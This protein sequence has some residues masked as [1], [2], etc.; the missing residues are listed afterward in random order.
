MVATLC[1]LDAVLWAL[2]RFVKSCVSGLQFRLH[3]KEWRHV[4]G[5]NTDNIYD[6][7]VIKEFFKND[8][9]ELINK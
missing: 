4:E 3:M 6:L 2:K 8:I 1:I 7:S 5:V 9:I